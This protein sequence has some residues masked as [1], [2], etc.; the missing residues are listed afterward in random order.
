[1][2]RPTCIFTLDEMANDLADDVRSL[3][4]ERHGI[5]E[6]VAVR[7]IGDVYAVIGRG[8]GSQTS[9]RFPAL[10]QVL[11][12]VHAVWQAP[13]SV[14][15]RRNVSDRQRILIIAAASQSTA[16]DAIDLARA[17][18]TVYDSLFSSHLHTC[19]LVLLLPDTASGSTPQ[20]YASAYAGL[21]EISEVAAGN[22]QGKRLCDFIW[23]ISSSNARRLRFP[24]VDKDSRVYAEAVVGLLSTEPELSGALP[25]AF[26]PRGFDPT[27]SS[28]GYAELVLP[29][30]TIAMRLEAR[31]A[32]ELVG[33]V[34]CET[35]VE[36][37]Q[38]SAELAAKTLLQNDSFSALLKRLDFEKGLV[39]SREFQPQTRMVEAVATV[40][41]ITA[42]MRGERE[43]FRRNA[44][45]RRQTADIERANGTVAA[46]AAAVRELRDTTANSVGFRQCIRVLEAL[47]DPFPDLRWDRADL[48]PRNLCSEI[49][50][51]S[52]ALDQTLGIQ[53]RVESQAMRAR[54]R[55]LRAVLQHQQLSEELLTLAEPAA[56]ARL[57][58]AREELQ[59]QFEILMAALPETIMREEL[60]RAEA[61][62]KATAAEQER[63][64]Q[65]TDDAERALADLVVAKQRSTE[66]LN[67]ALRIR[68]AFLHTHL[69]AR[70][71]AVALLL[72]GL[73]AAVGAA[74]PEILRWLVEGLGG[75][76]RLFTYGV[77][78]IVM[79][80]AAVVGRYLS[81]IHPS[82]VRAREQVRRVADSMPA[83][84]VRLSSAHAAELQFEYS[85]S[86]YETHISMLRR[87]ANEIRS[88]I[89]GVRE[90][91][92]DLE[93]LRE[94]F[95]KEHRQAVITTAARTL[96]AVTTEEVDYYYDHSTS[97]RAVATRD[98]CEGSLTRSAVLRFES[99]EIDRAV[100]DYVS[101]H[102]SVIRKMTLVD[103]A[104]GRPPIVAL[105]AFGRRAE[106]LLDM[107]SP[108]L[109]IREDI[110]AQRG[111]QKDVT[112]WT[113]GVSILS[114]LLKHEQGMHIRTDGDPLR[115]VT[116]GRT[117]HVP[118]YSL[119]Q[120]DYYR[121]QYLAEAPLDQTELVPDLVPTEFILTAPLR[122]TFVEL[123]VGQQ[124]GLVVR[125]DD[126]MLTLEGTGEEVGES[127][128]AAA[129][130][131]LS[132]AGRTARS[133]L[134]LKI[135]E[136]GSGEANFDELLHLF[137]PVAGK[138][139]GFDRRAFEAVRGKGILG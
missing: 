57:Q 78:M 50:T 62:P 8:E 41:D 44:L 112:V 101:A 138:L 52:E 11:M 70:P 20:M 54:A 122:S 130:K 85:M 46:A 110:E 56:E 121:S 71:I 5:S 76:A 104:A 59:R 81:A 82:V 64:A 109:E 123:I 118:G 30:D 120:I 47:I 25:G 119:A 100:R 42:A 37:A 93:A 68:R 73:G 79:Y 15:R 61:L 21:K 83:A 116:L 27:F 111:I 14:L 127:Y 107:G 91:V 7:T 35:A 58:P 135:Y 67:D 22:G 45:L 18:Q 6:L 139:H 13:T 124:L 72:V 63:L 60:S 26:R 12:S 133:S 126:G 38:R 128:F 77:G 89:V 96:S 31:F 106:R 29:V 32:E 3:I 16:R 17:I 113:G 95:S 88:L 39:I 87:L 99:N 132:P 131:L 129:Q 40:D 103:L 9:E 108:L 86:L 19:E 94:Q 84:F 24:P 69:V 80:A 65:V 125:R 4:A 23:I 75:S 55:E 117:L 28:F 98:F 10:A 134:K 51:A 137:D 53:G 49:D 92:A 115:I 33:E 66:A 90:R 105:D 136:R 97:E 114:E 102:Y 1:M 2:L 36:S 74:K 48:A 43:S 34:L